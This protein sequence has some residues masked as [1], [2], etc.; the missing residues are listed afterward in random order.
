M[1]TITKMFQCKVNKISDVN[2]IENE[3]RNVF[4]VYPGEPCQ[5]LM[6]TEYIR[7]KNEVKKRI[8]N[9]KTIPSYV[10]AFLP[11]YHICFESSSCQIVRTTPTLP[12]R[13]NNENGRMI[14]RRK[15]ATSN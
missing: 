9:P 14:K 3:L 4:N 11:G 6:T 7:W 5:C 10:D 2:K 8:Q 13:E 1:C 15:G 12:V